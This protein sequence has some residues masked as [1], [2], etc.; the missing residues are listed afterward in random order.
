MTQD[1]NSLALHP[2]V[3]MTGSGNHLS[4]SHHW[5]QIWIDVCPSEQ[6]GVSLPG[7]W[8]HALNSIN[9]AS[10]IGN[11]LGF[12]SLLHLNGHPEAQMTWCPFTWKG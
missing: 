4:L 2:E 3:T 10:T 12:Y 6:D 7:R 1:Y 11:L 9:M 8:S 5:F